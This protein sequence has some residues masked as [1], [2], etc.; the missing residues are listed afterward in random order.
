[1]K[2]F[3]E[4]VALLQRTYDA[5]NRRQI[6]EVL[7]MLD[8]EVSWPNLL[9]RRYLRG[10]RAVQE[11]WERQFQLINSQVE[12]T[13]FTAHGNVIIVDVRQVVRDLS[14]LQ[15]REQHVAHAYTFRGDLIAE[16]RVYETLEEALAVLQKEHS[17]A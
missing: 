5:F 8:P 1:M 7:S 16:M 4:W 14:T 13:D 3:E 10:H 9:E 2:T 6:D 11:Y 15:V 12:P 17:S